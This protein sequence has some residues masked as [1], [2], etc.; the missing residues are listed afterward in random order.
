MVDFCTQEP[1][2]GAAGQ[3]DFVDS[4]TLMPVEP[5]YLDLPFLPWVDIGDLHMLLKI[6]KKSVWAQRAH[7]KRLM[8]NN[9]VHV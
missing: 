8:R 3:T 1:L 7:E 9:L 4:W 2:P 5:E 6:G